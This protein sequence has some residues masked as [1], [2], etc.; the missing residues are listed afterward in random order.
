MSKHVLI[1]GTGSA[2][3]RHANN[4]HSLGCAISCMDPRPDRLDEI[5]SEEINLKNVFTSVEEAFGS[6]RL[7]GNL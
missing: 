5:K 3:K 7:R 6:I 2:G 4:L 1:I